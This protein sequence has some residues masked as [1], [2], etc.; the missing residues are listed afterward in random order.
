M[1]CCSEHCDWK[2]IDNM[3]CVLRIWSQRDLLKWMI[4]YRK[5]IVNGGA[6]ERMAGNP[7]ESSSYHQKNN[8]VRNWQRRSWDDDEWM[9]RATFLVFFATPFRFWFCFHLASSF[10]FQIERAY[11]WRSLRTISFSSTCYSKSIFNWRSLILCSRSV[12]SDSGTLLHKNRKK[13]NQINS[14]HFLVSVA[15]LPR[16]AYFNVR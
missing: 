4:V 15:W 13:Q 16:H 3:R 5:R 14:A 7:I 11:L 8:I 12:N 2:S 9:K 6:E 10:R 1:R